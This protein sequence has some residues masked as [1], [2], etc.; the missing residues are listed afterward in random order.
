MKDERALAED[1]LPFYSLSV[2]YGSQTGTA[3][4]QLMWIIITYSRTDFL[5][6]VFYVFHAP[7]NNGKFR[8]CTMHHYRCLYKLLIFTCNI[9]LLYLQI[10]IVHNSQSRDCC[11]VFRLVARY[12]HVYFIFS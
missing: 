11:Y 6:H 10:N 3:K 2:F 4:V 12:V 8:Y 1:T 9:S 7:Q 5:L